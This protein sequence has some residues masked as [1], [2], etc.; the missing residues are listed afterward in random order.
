MFKA[1]LKE[2]LKRNVL[3]FSKVDG[4]FPMGILNLK[5]EG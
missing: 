4:H 5:I 2:K 3:I 1:N